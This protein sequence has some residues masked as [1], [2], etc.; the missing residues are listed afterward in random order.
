MMR[1]LT[2]R[3]ELPKAPKESLLF[4]GSLCLSLMQELCIIFFI[5]KCLKMHARCSDLRLAW[6]SP[7]CL[8]HC[9]HLH[10]IMKSFLIKFVYL[11]FFVVLCRFMIPLH[12]CHQL[13]CCSVSGPPISIVSL[14]LSTSSTW[15]SFRKVG[16][17]FGMRVNNAKI[18]DLLKMFQWR[19][20]QC[21]Q[22]L[23]NPYSKSNKAH[24]K[25]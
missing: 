9:H 13:R 16:H 8:R 25:I 2:K 7:L 23:T 4:L 11:S 6:N 20:R 21:E 3:E 24:F 18:P 14:I 15:Y 17:C 22:Q 19:I 5:I 10:Q 1:L 12:L